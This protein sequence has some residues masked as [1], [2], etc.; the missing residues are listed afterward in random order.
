MQPRGLTADS[1]NKP[2]FFVLSVDLRHAAASLAGQFKSFP[3][4]M[5]VTAN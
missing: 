1:E 5:Y 2:L 4:N 3:Q